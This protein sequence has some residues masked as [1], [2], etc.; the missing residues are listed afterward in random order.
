MICLTLFFLKEQLKC[1]GERSYVNVFNEIKHF[2]CK[3]ELY[4][5]NEIILLLKKERSV[6]TYFHTLILR[7]LAESVSCG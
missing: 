6:R 4:Y 1:F 3:N 5:G 7:S 2:Y